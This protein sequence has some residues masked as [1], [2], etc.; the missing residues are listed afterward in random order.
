MNQTVITYLM[1]LVLSAAFTI[2]VAQTLHRNGRTFLVH[3]FRDNYSLADSINH[4]LVVG[5]YLINL[6]YIGL[7]L[8]T[9]VPIDAWQG[10]IEVLAGKVGTVLLILGTMHFT[11]L[12]V[13]AMIRQANPAKS[14]PQNHTF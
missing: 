12:G 14:E 6:G 13:F 4:L 3:I 11:N 1:Y 10:S 7:F 2:W 8:K 9:H 5:F